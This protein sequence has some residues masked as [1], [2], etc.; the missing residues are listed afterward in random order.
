MYVS[1]QEKETTRPCQALSRSSFSMLACV[2]TAQ[3]VMMLL[4]REKKGG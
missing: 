1:K 3:A 2:I 4:G